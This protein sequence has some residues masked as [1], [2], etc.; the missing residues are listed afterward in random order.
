MA[1]ASLIEE[2]APR[3]SFVPTLIASA[4]APGEMAIENALAEISCK[5]LVAGQALMIVGGY[6]VR[7]SSSVVARGP[8]PSAMRWALSMWYNHSSW[9]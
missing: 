6:I 3:E 2:M 1:A 7:V 5:Y 8:E 4:P 9:P